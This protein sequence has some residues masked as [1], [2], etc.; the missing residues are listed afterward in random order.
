MKKQKKFKSIVYLAAIMQNCASQTIRHS[1]IDISSCGDKSLD[2]SPTVASKGVKQRRFA[3]VNI[4]YIR[5]A[6]A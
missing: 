2:Q 4:V 3:V 5:A 1:L 6:F